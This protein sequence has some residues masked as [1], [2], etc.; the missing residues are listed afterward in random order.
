MCSLF[1]VYSLLHHTLLPNTVIRKKL[2][3]H[4]TACGVPVNDLRSQLSNSGTPVAQRFAKTDNIISITLK[5]GM[6]VIMPG[7]LMHCVNPVSSGDVRICIANNMNLRRKVQ[8]TVACE[9]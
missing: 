6:M 9:L 4:L 8:L 2:L 7:Q 5:V 1:L 3:Q